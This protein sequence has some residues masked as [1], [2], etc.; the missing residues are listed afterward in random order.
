MAEEVTALNADYRA[1]AVRLV[2]VC[3]F[4]V[5]WISQPAQVG[6]GTWG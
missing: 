1:Q 6:P 5:V 4:L 2:N 3:S